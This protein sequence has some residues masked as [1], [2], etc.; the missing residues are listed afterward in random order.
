MT[1]LLEQYKKYNRRFI[2]WWITTFVTI[3]IP[4]IGM[5]ASDE[6]VSLIL[7][8]QLFLV[9]LSITNLTIYG[10][11]K[12]SV[13]REIVASN[14]IDD[15]ELYQYLIDS[16]ISA[17]DARAY[18]NRPAPVVKNEKAKQKEKIVQCYIC[19]NCGSDRVVKAQSDLDEFFWMI[20]IF[21]ALG[22]VTPFAVFAFGAC[23]VMAVLTA[24]INKL[25]GITVKKLKCRSCGRK[26][27]YRNKVD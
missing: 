22:S 8:I 17:I 20:V 27:E 26:F 18:R 11:K 23:M 5:F 10:A 4:F 21:S 6:I 1:T 25:A 2:C 14:N 15:E 24:I 19:P 9:V 16:G 12:S 13:V 7:I 3:F